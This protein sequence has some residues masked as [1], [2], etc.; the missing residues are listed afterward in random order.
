MRSRRETKRVRGLRFPLPGR[1]VLLGIFLLFGLGF[2]LQGVEA[3]TYPN[4]PIDVIVPWNAGSATDLVPRVIVPRV[5]KDFGVPINVVNKPGAS[6]IT[7][8]LE[9][10][11]AKPDGYTLHADGVP[12]SVHIGAW[13]DLPYDPIHRTFIARAVDFPFTIVVKTDA[14]WKSIADVEQAVRKNPAAFRWSWLG[15]GGGVDI[16][17]AQLKAEFVKRGVELSQTKTVIFTGT[18]AVL[19]AV[20]GGHVDIAVGTPAVV[21]SMVSAGKARVIAISGAERYKGYPD[22]PS[23]AEQGYAGVTLGYWVGFFGPP[24]LPSAISEKWQAAIK[25]IVSDPE[26]G[27]KWDSLGGTPSFLG[28]EAFKNFVLKEA[29]M[30]RTVMHH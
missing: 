19:P 24:K 4:K 17:T 20:G 30:V 11:K 14:P 23:A 27:P 26:M 28:G 3:Q 29:E 25:A 8:T 1:M 6:G 10:L 7:G 9:A 12:V 16:V 13:K 22:V 15:G 18:A 5:S 21:K 2:F